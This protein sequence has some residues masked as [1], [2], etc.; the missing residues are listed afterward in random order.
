MLALLSLGFNILVVI[1]SAWGF[2]KVINNDLHHVQLKQKE[3]DDKL[4]D[5]VDSQEEMRI[6]LTR[7]EAK[8]Q[9]RHKRVRKV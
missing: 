4:S 3:H 6:T 9:E 1:I 8:C 7:I 2:I 5:I